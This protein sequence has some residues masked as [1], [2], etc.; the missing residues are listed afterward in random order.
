M[1]SLRVVNDSAEPFGSELRAELLTVEVLS[2]LSNPFQ[3]LVVKNQI[4]KFKDSE[5]VYTEPAERV[6]LDTSP[7]LLII[8][9]I[10]YIIGYFVL[11]QPRRGRNAQNQ[12]EKRAI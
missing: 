11:Y 3:Y 12:K 10:S 1:V 8:S 9:R 2:N 6:E 5:L 4:R 7:I